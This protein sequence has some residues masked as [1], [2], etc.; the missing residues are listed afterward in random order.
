MVATYLQSCY[1]FG[2]LFE[3]EKALETLDSLLTSWSH[4]VTIMILVLYIEKVSN[5]PENCLIKQDSTSHPH[6]YYYPLSPAMEDILCSFAQWME[7]NVTW[8]SNFYMTL[9]FTIATAINLWLPSSLRSPRIIG[10]C[11]ECTVTQPEV[12][13]DSAQNA[14]TD[15]WRRW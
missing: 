14:L 6:I 9:N 7:N 11:I 12:S 13:V 15:F 8:H 10:L 4:N 1:N 2:C 5:L 3:V